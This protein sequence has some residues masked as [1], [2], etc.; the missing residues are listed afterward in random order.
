VDIDKEKDTKSIYNEGLLQI[1]RLHQCWAECNYY[2][3]RAMMDKWRWTLD[4]IWRELSYDAFKLQDDEN[5]EESMKE[6]DL[7]INKAFLNKNRSDVY[8]LLSKKEISLR[9]LQHKVG[10]GA[11]YEDNDFRDID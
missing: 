8:S 7:D 4:V 1:Q 3:R 6:L 5:W 10:K 9:I 11:K 2:S